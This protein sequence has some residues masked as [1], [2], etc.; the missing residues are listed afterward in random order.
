M[1]ERISARPPV[2]SL[3]RALPARGPQRAM[4]LSSFVN[5][6]GNGLFNTASVLY[7]TRVVHL[8]AGRLGLGLTVAGLIGLVA[9]V[10][11]GALA[12]RRGPRAVVLLT[13]AAQTTSMLAFLFVRNTVEF[14]AVATLDL[15]ALSANNAAR[16]ALIV[17]VG[18]ERPA[19][20]RARLRTFTNLGVVLGTFGAATAVE[21]D[22]RAAYTALILLNAA[23]Y[24][25]CGLL[26]L[27]VPAYPAVPA[28]TRTGRWVALRDR[29]FALVAALDGA[30]GLQYQVAALL[31]PIWLAQHTAAPRWT[32]AAVSAL[33]SACCVLFQIP[34]GSR[35]NSPGEGGQA[36]RRAGLL[37]LVSCPL[38]ALTADLPPWAAVALVLPAMVAHSLGEVCQSSASFALGFG[39]APD[40]AQG[41]YQGLLGLGFD[42]GQ[43]VAPALL[44]SVCLGLGQRG[45]LLLGAFFALLGLLA[46]P[47]AG[48]AERTRPQQA[49]VPA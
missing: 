24:V 9:G 14:T 43:A 41:Q 42:T 47:L 10:P 16:G 32:V 46:P 1:F 25:G 36:M 38:M 44:T 48:W 19:A 28:P 23:S 29:P 35:V 30:M 7:F 2:R 13:L 26:L 49:P 15:L 39:L 34:I 45:W 6:V 12:D 4:V 11:A 37:F 8:P 21:L 20:F 40:H 31:L 17:R 27:R 3:L 18:G 5:R 22:T 33:N